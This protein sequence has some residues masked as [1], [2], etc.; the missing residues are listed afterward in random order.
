MNDI[1]PLYKY[2]LRDYWGK[3]VK[4]HPQY[5]TINAFDYCRNERLSQIRRY[6]YGKKINREKI[7]QMID[8]LSE[9]LIQIRINETPLRPSIFVRTSYS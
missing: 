2:V 9:N 5:G 7:M 1:N 4:W 6:K 3:D 8:R